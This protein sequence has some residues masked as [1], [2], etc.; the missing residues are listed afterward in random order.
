MFSQR[1][2]LILRAVPTLFIQKPVAMATKHTNNFLNESEFIPSNQNIL[3][4]NAI[5]I[6]PINGPSSSS[7]SGKN[8]L[9]YYYKFIFYIPT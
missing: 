8:F 7:S 5:N 4:N 3:I 9:F 2:R 6:S 1:K